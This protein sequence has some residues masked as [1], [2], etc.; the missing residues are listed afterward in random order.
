[1]GF[2]CVC[3]VGGG[4]NVLTAVKLGETVVMCCAIRNS[5][6]SEAPSFQ[7]GNGGIYLYVQHG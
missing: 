6:K 1:M 2:K 7:M 4:G 3:R 5:C